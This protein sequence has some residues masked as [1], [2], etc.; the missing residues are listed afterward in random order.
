MIYMNARFLT[1][2]LTGVQRYAY[3]LAQRLPLAQLVTP[4]EPRP[5]YSSLDAGRIRVQQSRLP[6]HLWE[7]M[8]LPRL[9]PKDALL[10]SPGSGPLSVRR[11]V[12][13]IHDMAYLEGPQWYSRSY[14]L[15]YRPLYARLAPRARLVLTV[16]EF[17]KQ[18][19]VELLKVPERNVRVTPLAIN[20]RFRPYPLEDVQPVLQRLGVPSPYLLAV[21][22]VSPRKNFEGIYAA[23]T[24]LADSY[25]DLHLVVVGKTGL[26][27]S[28]GNTTTPPPARTHFLQDVPD[29]DLIRLYN[30]A[31]AF[32][33]PSLYEGFGLPALE[34]AACGTPVVTSNSTSLPEVMGDAAVFVDPYEVESIADGIRRVV[35]DAALREQL[36]SRGLERAKLFHWDRTA[37]LT[38]QALQEAVAR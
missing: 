31:L 26:A 25:P 8:I 2:P 19:I 17:S 7:Q 10:W 32:L 6:G 3:E 28:G 12:L 20:P 13:T 14:V 4:E 18:R 24:R 38:W 34:A 23:W 37:E 27:F 15:L 33:Y 9:L 5:H 21:S 11:Q 35:E 1:Q 16:S 36:R 29:D 22:A 30:G